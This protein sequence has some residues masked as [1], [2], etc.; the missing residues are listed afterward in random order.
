MASIAGRQP[1]VQAWH[2]S[3]FAL[4]VQLNNAL[5]AYARNMGDAIGQTEFANEVGICAFAW[6]ANDG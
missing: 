2:N 4:C 6:A 1:L 3:K 5:I